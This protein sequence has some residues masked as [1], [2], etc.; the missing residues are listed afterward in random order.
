[1]GIGS[2]PVPPRLVIGVIIAVILT[3]IASYLLCSGW[4][5]V[6][7]DSLPNENMAYIYAYS[8]GFGSYGY[9]SGPDVEGSDFYQEAFAEGY[10]DAEED[11]N[12]GYNAG[13]LDFYQ[14]KS[15][16]HDKEWHL[17]HSNPWI[18]GYH[19]GY[20]QSHGGCACGE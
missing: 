10:Y 6:Y 20:N 11:W 9:I 1:M 15:D 18:S 5:P 16:E 19:E 8:A 14:N 4:T 3:F 13:I 2:A 12:A 7:D 17:R